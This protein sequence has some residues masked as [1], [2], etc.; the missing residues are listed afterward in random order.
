MKERIL[1]MGPPSSG[2]TFQLL[3]V[4]D[5]LT[6]QGVD[7]HIIDL[8]DKVEA[9]IISQGLKL[10]KNFSVATSW[11]EYRE[12]VSGINL[13][14]NNWVLVDRVDLSW[15]A[16]QRWFTQQKYEEEL[17]DRM[18]KKSLEMKKSSMFIPR[19]DQG[20]W[21]VINEAYESTMGK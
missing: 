19:F 4:Y 1:L 17:A 2:K 12:A 18:L 9:S 16:V 20:S 14:P 7:C 11:E 10:P 15:P 13:K 21:Q 6:E 5:T 8:E 3:R